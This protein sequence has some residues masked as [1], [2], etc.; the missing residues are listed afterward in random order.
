MDAESIVNRPLLSYAVNLDIQKL[1][2]GLHKEE[3]IERQKDIKYWVPLRKELEI[4]RH[5][6]Q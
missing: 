1:N 6:K 3:L 2:S 5:K 4:L